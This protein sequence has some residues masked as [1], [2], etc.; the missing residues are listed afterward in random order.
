MVISENWVQLPS[1]D[2]DAHS[3]SFLQP[4]FVP[5]Q[6][7]SCSSLPNPSHLCRLETTIPL[8]PRPALS[9]MGVKPSLCS[10]LKLFDLRFCCLKEFFLIFLWN[11]PLLNLNEENKHLPASESSSTYVLCF[12]LLGS[13][14]WHVKIKMDRAGCSQG[15]LSADALISCVFSGWNT[16]GLVQGCSNSP[17]ISF[18]RGE[19]ADLS[20]HTEVV[21]LHLSFFPCWFSFSSCYTKIKISLCYVLAHA[22]SPQVACLPNK[23]N[24]YSVG[25]MLLFLLLLV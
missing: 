11:E 2:Q 20:A 13:R 18:Q 17:A 5:A 19:Q 1:D 9:Q 7:S 12:P 22:Y 10:L 24:Y 25:E 4:L 3:R 16:Q 6:C 15:S 21:S 14:C 23:R 8:K